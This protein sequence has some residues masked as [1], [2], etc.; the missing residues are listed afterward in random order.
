MS[1]LFAMATTAQAQAVDLDQGWDARTLANWQ[2]LS[3]GSRYMPLS[4]ADALEAPG[5]QGRFLTEQNI[6]RYGY[7]AYQAQYQG[8][9]LLLPMG[10]VPDDN[11]D[12]H[13]SYTRLRWYQ[14]QGNRELW[15]GMNCSACHTST[16]QY[17]GQR[18]VIQG[19]PTNA[20]FQAFFDDLQQAMRETQTDTA[21]FSRFAQAVLGERENAENRQ[22]LK[23]SLTQLNAFYARNSELNGDVAK[24][25]PGR[26][27]A[28]GHI[29]NKVS[30]I[31]GAPNP[32]A[33]PADAPVSYP[34]L[35]NVPQHDKVQ[36]NGMVENQRLKLLGR[37]SI[38]VGAL[39][40]NVGEVIGVYA[41]V[42]PVK[43][44]GLLR[45]FVSSVKVKN[46]EVLEESLRTL[47][48]PRWPND[49]LGEPKPELVAEGKGVYDALNCG[50]CH[51][52]LER[53]D[54]K[55]PIKAHMV[56]IGSADALDNNPQLIGTDPGMACNAFQYAS[57]SGVLAGMTVAT[58]KHQPKQVVQPYDK[59]ANMLTVT[60]KQTLLGQR[61]D[62]AELVAGGFVGIPVKPERVPGFRNRQLMRVE[63]ERDLRQ[64]DCY[65][66]AF[67]QPTLAYKARPLT[68]I[69]A[70]A[71][72]LHNGSV[73]SLYELLLA[74]Q[75]RMKVF[76]TGSNEF[77]PKHVGFV[78]TEGE[79][80][81]FKFDTQVRGNSNDGHDY[82]VGALDEGRRLALLEYLKTL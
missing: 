51:A 19:G 43:D 82:G 78:T 69:W 67:T 70:T 33:N 4:W 34:F 73:A 62:V 44:P 1:S 28:V 26:L 2:Q 14:N 12:R 60:A 46:L 13:L 41:D 22:L 81:L 37:E 55:T 35:W 57:S 42:I 59:V 20:D 40:R 9:T 25:G 11:D 15:L 58:P 36:W 79:G 32:Q 48:P 31:S 76:Y 80:N 77:D 53:T 38:D 3:Q 63:D 66:A 47:K 27:D 24:Y 21:K 16:V 29:L 17:N 64:I 8:R 54:L 75:Q 56:T 65:K 39:G 49:V 61:H 68:G 74:P 18:M 72:Y 30:Q 50:S 10:F 23:Q 7:A 6:A 71:P 5:Q 45:G 52:K